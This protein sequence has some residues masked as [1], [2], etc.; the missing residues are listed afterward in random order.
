MHEIRRSNERGFADHGWL[1]S[2]TLFPS[3][4]TSIPTT[5]N[6]SFA[7][8]QRG[9]RA[10]RSGFGTHSHRDMEIVSYV[11][12]AGSRTR[13]RSATG[14]DRTG[15]RA[16]DDCRH[17]RAAQRIQSE[18]DEPCIFSRYGFNRPSAISRPATRRSASRRR[19]SAGAA[20]DR[21]PDHAEGSLTFIKTRK[22]TRACSTA[23]NARNSRCRR[24][25]H[26]SARRAGAIA[27]NGTALDAGDALRIT[28]ARF[29]GSAKGA[30]RRFWCSIYRRDQ[31]Q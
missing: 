28:T 13:I 18:H 3:P 17:R 20:P 7:R 1:K 5:S 11:L 24:A 9:S 27:A 23:R 6:S 12:S 31:Y 25:A 2:S 10:S 29:F 15:R 30:T 8:H 21:L 14:R 19:R 16:A 22:S 26:L 4:T